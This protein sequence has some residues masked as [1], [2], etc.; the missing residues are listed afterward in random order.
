MQPIHTLREVFGRPAYAASAVAIA[1]LSAAL[2]A[3]SGQVV[4]VFPEGGVF[5]DADVLTITGLG[6][7]ALLL[8][9]TF[10]LHWYAWRRSRRAARAGGIGA[11]GAVFSVGSLSCCA[12]LLVPGALSLL[13]FSGS[14]LLALNL[15]LHQLRLPLTL[16]AIAFLVL[17]VWIGLRD[18]AFSCRLAP[19]R[20][21]DEDRG[22][23]LP[24][25]GR[26]AADSKQVPKPKP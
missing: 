23:H 21:L 11:L 26:L 9:V 6:L 24:A 4:T 5:V 13:G 19:S 10:P 2:L 1:L 14:S 15:R 20:R 3:W 17:S 8:G 16:L 22:P 18:V 12:P 7:A 25:R